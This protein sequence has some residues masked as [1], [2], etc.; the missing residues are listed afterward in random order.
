MSK[1]K[2]IVIL[3]EEQKAAWNA[4]ADGKIADQPSIP[5]NGLGNEKPAGEMVFSDL[6][7]GQ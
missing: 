4:W 5:D 6:T 3:S 7:L 1:D 2:T